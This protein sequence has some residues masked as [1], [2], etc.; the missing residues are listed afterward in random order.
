MWGK[1]K[2]TIDTAAIQAIRWKG[3]EFQIQGN[4]H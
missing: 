2:N 4:L 1:K 3:H